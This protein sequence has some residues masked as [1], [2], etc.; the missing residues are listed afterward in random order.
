MI[1]VNNINSDKVERVSS[2][3]RTDE[4]KDEQR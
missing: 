3:V 4:D 1:I 2:I